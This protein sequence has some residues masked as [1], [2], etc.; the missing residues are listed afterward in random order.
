MQKIGQ[1]LNRNMIIAIM[2]PL[3]AGLVFDRFITSRVVEV[4][5]RLTGTQI[6]EYVLLALIVSLGVAIN[7][8]MR[9]NNDR[10]FYL[11]VFLVIALVIATFAFTVLSGNLA[12]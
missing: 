6:L 8:S 4:V 2:G 7:G 5:T 10:H 11:I 1:V 12:F 9:S 3:L